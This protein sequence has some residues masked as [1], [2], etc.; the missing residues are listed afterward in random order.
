MELQVVRCPRDGEIVLEGHFEGVVRVLCPG[1]G[2]R[3]RVH[4]MGDGVR[5][6]ATLV[7]RPP[8]ALQHSA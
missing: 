4:V 7:D 2:P 3:H 5:L 1:R 6:E 8:V